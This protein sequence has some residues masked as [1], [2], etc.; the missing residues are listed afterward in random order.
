MKQIAEKVEL[1]TS[2]IIGTVSVML[3]KPKKGGVAD[4]I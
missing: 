2:K 3:L 1:Y 4:I